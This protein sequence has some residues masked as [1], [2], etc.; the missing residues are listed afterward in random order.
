MKYCEWLSPA[1]VG[2]RS[3]PLT[4]VQCDG[5]EGLRVGVH[6]VGKQVGGLTVLGPAGTCARTAGGG[7]EWG[8]GS[9][10][11]V[12]AAARAGGW[13]GGWER[14][15]QFGLRTFDLRAHAPGM[16]WGGG[17]LVSH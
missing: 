1:A 7:V 6:D 13:V 15:C 2:L 9:S 4:S 8:C 11:S 3:A 5:H 12:Q 14:L 17:A 10:T 16:R